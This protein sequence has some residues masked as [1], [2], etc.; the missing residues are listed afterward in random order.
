MIQVDP[1]KLGDRFLLFNLEDLFGYFDC[2]AWEAVKM[3]VNMKKVKSTCVKCDEF[4]LAGCVE[5]ESCY[6]W[7]HT[8]C[9]DLDMS[10]INDSFIFKCNSCQK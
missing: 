1:K 9:I 5:C 2:D 6:Q 3:V 4:C 8:D 10:D 7:Y